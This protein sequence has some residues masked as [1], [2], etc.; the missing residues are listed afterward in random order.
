MTS[1][2][3]KSPKKKA[4]KRKKKKRKKKKNQQKRNRRRSNKPKFKM[5]SNSYDL[6]TDSL[7]S[8]TIRNNLFNILSID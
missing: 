5:S 7:N 1:Q 4:N 8:K 6:F 3:R 2:R